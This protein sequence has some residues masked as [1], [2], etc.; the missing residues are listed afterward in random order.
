MKRVSIILTISLAYLGSLILSN[1]ASAGAPAEDTLW[2]FTVLNNGTQNCKAKDFAYCN[3]KVYA[4]TDTMDLFEYTPPNPPATLV[5]NW[6]LKP[7]ANWSGT[8]ISDIGLTTAGHF[9]RKIDP[10]W[11]SAV[12]PLLL[13]HGN[14]IYITTKAG[15]FARGTGAGAQHY[16]WLEYNILC[17]DPVTNSS[18]SVLAVATAPNSTTTLS[19]WFPLYNSKARTTLSNG[20][21]FTDGIDVFW[22][23]GGGG[24]SGI[25][26]EGDNDLTNTDG[27][28]TH[29]PHAPLDADGLPAPAIG[30]VDLRYVWKVTSPGP[31]VLQDRIKEDQYGRAVPMAMPN[32]YR[33][34]H[35][36]KVD[37][38]GTERFWDY[39]GYYEKI[40]DGPGGNIDFAFT[41]KTNGIHTEPWGR[42][43]MGAGVIDVTKQLIRVAHNKV[44]N[45]NFL[46][47]IDGTAGTW[48]KF[49]SGAAPNDGT[50]YWRGCTV[51]ENVDIAGVAGDPTFTFD[52]S[53]HNGLYAT[54]SKNCGGGAFE[55][56]IYRYT[57][58]GGGWSWKISPVVSVASATCFTGGIF[59]LNFTGG[60]DPVQDLA[61]GVYVGTSN[62]VYI[63]QIGEFKDPDGTL[64]TGNDEIGVPPQ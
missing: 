4:L 16:A 48:S 32:G 54:Y 51:V 2:K 53:E 10:D 47:T 24:F 7:K 14:K 35:L 41:P 59:S 3:G 13:S 42:F 31:P 44:G 62:G 11:S 64:W 29:G 40:Y 5:G 49:K 56:G 61:A 30:G 1:Q 38:G 33:Y 17:Y 43:Q 37:F 55:S 21:L 25:D 19:K 27:T 58:A 6:T 52:E 28:G 60:T 34:N 45:K 39:Y 46:Y 18:S 22:G 20:Y 12:Y 36:V 50:V 15:L 23:G 26:T 63:R 8:T 57:K 9:I